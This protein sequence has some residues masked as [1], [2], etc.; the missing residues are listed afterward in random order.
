MWEEH[1]N[2]VA[3]SRGGGAP[4]CLPLEPVEFA[5]M[6]RLVFVKPCIRAGVYSCRKSFSICWALAPARRNPA[7]RKCF[8]APSSS[9]AVVDI[10]ITHAGE[11]R[12][13]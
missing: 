7:R 5:E 6:E 3:Q 1:E 13:S 10:K 4:G 9:R 11:Y 8:S 2:R 12:A